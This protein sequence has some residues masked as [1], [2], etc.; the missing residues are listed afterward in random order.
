[1][2]FPSDSFITNHRLVH[3]STH[4]S[5]EQGISISHPPPPPRSPPLQAPT[6]PTTTASASAATC[7]ATCATPTA[8][9]PVTPPADH[10]PAPVWGGPAT[11]AALVSCSPYNSIS[12]TQGWISR[13]VWVLMLLPYRCR[14]YFHADSLL[15][16][17]FVPLPLLS[18]TA[19]GRP[20]HPQ[21]TRDHAQ[22]SLHDTLML[23]GV[24]NNQRHT[25]CCSLPR[26][27]SCLYPC[28]L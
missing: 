21:P 17:T 2:H 1:M 5:S 11:N 25:G 23:A 4:Q 19:S 7:R 15:D 22:V 27:S 8:P 18:A 24:Y 10:A 20:P 9:P 6:Q 28:T 14:C 26:I 13:A 12:L 16:L 3:Q